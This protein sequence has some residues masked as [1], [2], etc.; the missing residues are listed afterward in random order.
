MISHLSD[1]EIVFFWRKC[2]CFNRVHPMAIPIEDI[3]EGAV[4]DHGDLVAVE[5]ELPFYRF[6]S[7]LGLLIIHIIKKSI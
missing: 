6:A 4:A 3:G 2:L 5:A 7:T 1:D